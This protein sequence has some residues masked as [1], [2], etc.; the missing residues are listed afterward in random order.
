MLVALSVQIAVWTVVFIILRRMEDNN[1]KPFA[2][3]QADWFFK[4]AFTTKDPVEK[5]ICFQEAMGWL[6][7]KDYHI[8]RLVFE[9]LQEAGLI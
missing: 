3:R 9:D 1:S 4:E 6:G 8:I 2:K 5:A 7:E